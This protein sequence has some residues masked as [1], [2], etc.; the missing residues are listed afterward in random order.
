MNTK[1]FKSTEFADY[2]KREALKII[3]EEKIQSFGDATDLDM[4]KN[5]SKALGSNGS[6]VYVSEKGK[7]KIKTEAP[8]N[9][10]EEFKSMKD[11]IEVKMKERDGGHDEQISTATKI[12]GSKS[13]KSATETNPFVGG[14][15]K[16][17]VESKKNQPNVSQDA[18]PTKIGGVPGNKDNNVG[19]NKE[20]KEDKS[21]KPMTQVLGKGEISKDGFSK[22]QTNKDINEKAQNE[23]DAMEQKLR[24]SIKTIQLAAKLHLWL[25]VSKRNRFVKFTMAE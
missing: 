12:E 16:P 20:D 7:F 2:V 25:F 17:N 24:D 8:T 13:T 21:K 4:N 11:P 6:K 1:K 14:Q 19:M 3:N 18:D 5:D 15:A 9:T 10:P 22:G 23:N